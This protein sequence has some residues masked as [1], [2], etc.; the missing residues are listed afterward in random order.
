[1]VNDIDSLNSRT[2]FATNKFGHLQNVNMVFL[3]TFFLKGS[4]EL[5]VKHNVTFLSNTW[6]EANS[7]MWWHSQ[8]TKQKLEILTSLVAGV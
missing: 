1:M 4:T 7:N 2:H 3:S 5:N 6:F 8:F